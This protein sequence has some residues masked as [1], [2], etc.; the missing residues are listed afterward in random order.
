MLIGNWDVVATIEPN[1]TR[2]G[3][4]DTGA[5]RIVRGPGVCSVIQNYYTD[6]H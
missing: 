4:K 1:A 3:G 2:Q 5:N 6:G